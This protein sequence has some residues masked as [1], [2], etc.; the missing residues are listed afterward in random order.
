[1]IPQ[2]IEYFTDSVHFTDM[3]TSLVAENYFD[4]IMRNGLPEKVQSI[5]GN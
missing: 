3:G 5:T 4:A 1:M 2:E